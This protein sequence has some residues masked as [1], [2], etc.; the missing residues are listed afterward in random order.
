[1][2]TSHELQSNIEK[3]PVKTLIPFLRPDDRKTL[4]S[5]NVSFVNLRRKIK[6]NYTSEIWRKGN[7]FLKIGL[8]I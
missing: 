7:Y 4:V 3:G 1:M 5:Q 2:Q 8:R 6:I